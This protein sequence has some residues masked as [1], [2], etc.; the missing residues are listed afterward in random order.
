MY[1]KLGGKEIVAVSVIAY[2]AEKTILETLNSVL[3]QSY[4]CENIELVI[5]D[6]CSSDNTCR[7]IDKWLD[8]FSKKFYDCQLLTKYKNAG[9]TQNVNTAWKAVVASNWVKTI[10]A[11]DVL[12]QNCIDVL[13][14]YIESHSDCNIVFSNAYRFKISKETAYNDDRFKS[15]FY[16]LCPSQQYQV[17]LIKNDIFA[18]TSFI[19]ISFLQSLGYA[20]ERFPM[21][22]DLPL[23]LKITKQGIKLHGIDIN[24]V[25]YRLDDSVSHN[26]IK[27]ANVDYL[28]S[29]VKMYKVLIWPELGFKYFFSI[30]DKKNDLFILSL[31]VQFFNNKRS[32]Y[33]V[34]FSKIVK[35]FSPLYLYQKILL[36]MK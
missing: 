7:V 12:E 25:Y 10:A 35:L 33:F 8:N 27:I 9:V 31:G 34:I 16:A 5:S 20:D 24:T 32:K 11:D 3:E 21:I 30:W 18:P 28:N 15:D 23:W 22:E 29:K 14:G 26:L 13:F 17:L 6:D 2:N 19:N 36:L 1:N 4:G